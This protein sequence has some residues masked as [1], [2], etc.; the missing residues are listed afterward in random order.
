MIR[1]ETRAYLERRLGRA[2]P[3]ADAKVTLSIAALAS[4]VDG[5]PQ[6]TPSAAHDGVIDALGD[7]VR[8]VGRSARR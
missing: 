5:A 2:L 7:L 8:E 4:I 1:P 6:P 3:N